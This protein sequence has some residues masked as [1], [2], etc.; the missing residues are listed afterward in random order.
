MVDG[1][2]SQLFV[3]TGHDGHYEASV[4]MVHLKPFIKFTVHKRNIKNKTNKQKVGKFW[5]R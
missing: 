4:Y 3:I 1:G 5:I 2:E